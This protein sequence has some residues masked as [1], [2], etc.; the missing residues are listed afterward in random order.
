MLGAGLPASS[1]RAAARPWAVVV[2]VRRA[3]VLL[4]PVLPLIAISACSRQLAPLPEPRVGKFGASELTYT[5]HGPKVAILGDSLTVMGWDQLYDALDHHYAV[6]I[7]AWLGEG[8]NPGKFSDALRGP[9]LIPAAAAKYAATKPSV[10]VLALGTND[11]W[12]RRST[13]EALAAMH[14]LVIGF[15]GACLVGVTLPEDSHVAGWSNAEA[16]ALN[17]A[18]RAWAEQIVDWA[19]LSN[20][21][22]VLR[23]DGIHTTRAGTKL[24]ANAIVAAVQRCQQPHRPRRGRGHHPRRLE[25]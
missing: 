6:A 13:T 22:G 23:F 15:H 4:L 1:T 9:P 21:A 8:Y 25:S 2:A 16:H 14:A 5:G 3:I 7:T 20:K 24:R 19:S 17:T 12:N 11:A 18:M 10:V